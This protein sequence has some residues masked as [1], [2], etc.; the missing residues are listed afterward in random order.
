MS[1]YVALLR[2]I[3]ISGKNKIV[4]SELQSAFEALGFENVATYIN[5]GNVVFSSL[6][7][8]ESELKRL[9]EQKIT[10][11][12]QLEIPIAIVSQ[13]SL[14]ELIINAPAWWDTNKGYVT[15]AIFMIPPMTVQE[16]FESVGAIKPQ[17]EQIAHHD[18]VIFW[19]T[20]RH[21][22]NKS[23]WSKIASSS[24]NNQVTI[25]NI[26]TTYKIVGM[27]KKISL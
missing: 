4:M 24:V 7:Q 16:V 5:S 26:N 22:F 20:L 8:D 27:M 3:N 13:A 23:K 9:C 25:R 17:Y 18:Q 1:V 6:I 11:Q 15:Y 12:F 19:R 10:E 14:N 21:D 2:G